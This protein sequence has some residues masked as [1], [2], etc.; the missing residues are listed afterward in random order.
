MSESFA[1]MVIYAVSIFTVNKLFSTFIQ[2]FEGTELD[3]LRNV[4]HHL[5]FSPNTLWNL[6]HVIKKKKNNVLEAS[7]A[8]AK[9]SKHLSQKLIRA[10][11][12]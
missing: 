10:L 3:L 9:Y 5:L 4:F 11:H 7:S 1:V 12:T 2:T 8:T 6:A